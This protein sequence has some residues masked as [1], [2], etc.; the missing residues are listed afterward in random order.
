MM[1]KLRYILYHLGEVAYLNIQSQAQISDKR[2]ISEIISELPV[3]AYFWNGR[4]WR[5]LEVSEMHTIVLKDA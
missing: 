3:I 1:Y 4:T 5:S 2:L